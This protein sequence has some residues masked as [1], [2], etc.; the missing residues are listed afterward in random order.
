MRD[1]L[2]TVIVFIGCIYTLKRPYIGVLLW[3]WLSYMNPHRLAY[4][5]AYN[6][7]FA[8]ITALT[9]LVSM[10]LSKDTRKLPINS[11]TIIWLLFVPFM[12]L[13]TIFAFFPENALPDYIRTLKIQ[14]I[15]FLTMM[16]ITD[17]EK[18]K[19]LLWVIVLSIGY[20]SVKGG[21]F[22]L[23]TAGSY[24][25]W[26]PSESFISDN[27]SLAVAV[28][29]AIP[30]MIY[31]YQTA[32]KK[33]IKYGLLAASILSLFTIIGSQSRGAFLA[34]AAVGLSYWFKSEHKIITGIIIAMISIGLLAFAPDSWHK[35][36]NTIETYEEDASSMGR[37][38]AWE[39]AF[40]VANDN[41]LGAGQNSW[42]PVT[43][44]MYAPNPLDIHAAH[45][46]YFSV[47]ADHGWIGLF[48]F[49]LIF[50]L[51][52]KSLKNLIKT[53]ADKPNLNEIYLLSK[54]L[55][56]SF[57][58]YFVG[59]AFLSLSYFD[60]PWH[61]VSFVVI[62]NR[63]VEDRDIVDPIKLTISRA[64]QLQAQK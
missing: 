64:K 42:G 49:L 10:F 52:W 3:S 1:L 41:L 29:M 38:N 24:R 8:Q 21:L 4:G 16:L 62:L 12:G 14:L 46:I 44:A 58:A 26:G 5:F 60:L 40:N 57:M 20:F 53:T 47:L 61:L 35:R 36:M 51:S 28:L 9:L 48:M 31:L 59:G 50:Y 56:V 11:I 19:Q 15:V 13:T 22:A 17:M 34:I 30:L 2:V 63:M 39:Y 43:F 32:T 27:N 55:Q 54:M 18:L 25:I 23:M 6:M 33:W 7:P 45:S 37:L